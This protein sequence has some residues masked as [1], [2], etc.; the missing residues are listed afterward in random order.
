M[1]LRILPYS[2]LVLLSVLFFMSPDSGRANELD[3]AMK[4][5]GASSFQ[6]FH[7]KLL[8]LAKAG[9][10]RAQSNLGALYIQGVGVKQ[11]FSK[12]RTWLS[13][14]AAQGSASAQQTLGAMYFEGWGVN[15]NMTTA[16]RWYKQA[17]EGGNI[18]AEMMLGQ[19]Y[20]KGIGVA[21]DM[22]EALRWYRKAA[23]KGHVEAQYN[24]GSLLLSG[25]KEIRDPDQAR[26]WLERS[27]KAGYVGATYNLGYI[28]WKGVGIPVNGKRAWGHFVKAA[29]G[30]SAKGML[31]LGVMRMNGKYVER[32]L[33]EAL[34]WAVLAMNLG[35]KQGGTKLIRHLKKQRMTNDQ[36]KRADAAAKKWYDAH[37]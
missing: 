1:I 32:D 17:G 30:G 18:N 26:M 9:D 36:M 27:S 31:N 20:E 14:A 23:E 5:Y 3:T 21:L 6:E 15:K 29:E 4:E 8:P 24:Y 2:T 22:T 16:F 7:E 13:K 37:K 28:Y 19:L 33:T 34:K 35:E 25:P 11:D 10:A 12:A